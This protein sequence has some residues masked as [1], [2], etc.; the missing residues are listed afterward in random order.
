MF[1]E[2]VR[3]NGNSPAVGTR[4]SRTAQVETITYNELLAVVTKMQR[5]LHG[6]GLQQ[7]DRFALM[8]HDNRAE[9][10][11]ADLA[12]QAL[13]II[14]VPIYGTLPAS[15]VEFY[16]RDSDAAAIFV[17]DAKQRLKVEQ[18]RGNLPHLKTIISL[19]PTDET[20]S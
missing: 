8:F 18:V 9:W 13:G 20:H 3:A 12:S 1:L 6:L 15:Q 4:K 11:I 19:E 17:S 14:T 2:T 7:G 16:L 5:A 10:A